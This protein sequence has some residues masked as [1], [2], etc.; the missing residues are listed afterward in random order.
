MNVSSKSD[1]LPIRSADPV[2]MR[3]THYSALLN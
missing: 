1:R 2:E 3:L